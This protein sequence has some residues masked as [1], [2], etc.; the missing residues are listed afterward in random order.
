MPHSTTKLVLAA[1]GMSMIAFGPGAARAVEI[2]EQPQLKT[3]PG[4]APQMYLFLKCVVEDDWDESGGGKYKIVRLFNTSNR[5]LPEGTQI[6]WRLSTG[7]SGWWK[8]YPTPWA[9][10]QP[11]TAYDVPQAARY[12]E[13]LTCTAKVGV[14]KRAII[15]RQPRM[16]R[17]IPKPK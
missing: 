4:V 12:V 11:S 16:R 10:S 14:P 2:A 9:P 13:G 3:S 6:K 17:L 1:F 7:H 8:L 15:K 5:T